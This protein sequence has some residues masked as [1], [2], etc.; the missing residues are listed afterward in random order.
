MRWSR[1]LFFALLVALAQGCGSAGG[2]AAADAQVDPL[3]DA[4]LEPPEDVAPVPDD[5]LPTVNPLDDAEVALADDA[6]ED[7]PPTVADAGL[8]APAMHDAATV[9]DASTD[10]PA[11]PD[12]A[13]D[14]TVIRD[15]PPVP[16]PPAFATIPWEH[17]G[18]GVSFRDARVPGATGVF[19][20]YGG[21]GTT[22]AEVQAW[23]TALYAAGLR[24]RNV[25]WVYA[26]R[27]PSDFTYAAREIDNSRLIAR[28]LPQLAA[29]TQPALVA[30]HSAGG[31]VACELFQL[32]FEQGHDPHGTARGRLSYYN[33]DGIYGCLDDAEVSRLHHAY[34]VRAHRGSGWSLD[35]NS[36][37]A[38][39]ARWPRA[40]GLWNYDATSTGCH[41]DSAYC[42]HISLINTRPHDPSTALRTLDYSDFRGRPVNTW[43]LD[44]TPAALRP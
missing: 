22:D 5:A 30:A 42:L 23:I 28:M 16:A 14:V 35:A 12:A 13:V 25:R 15:V 18:T 36:M 27:G 21:Y 31:F 37:A 11:A 26:V 40:G 41:P 24:T 3:D 10:A 33:L 43:Y 29:S 1:A 44:A 34:F 20:G 9:R 2:D 19:I 17:V 7:A 39:A 32:L 38:G 6:P 8:D 4:G